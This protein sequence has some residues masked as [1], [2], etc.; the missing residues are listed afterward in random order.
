MDQLYLKHYLRTQINRFK[1]LI[2]QLV[3]HLWVGMKYLV[4]L[5]QLH[6]KCFNLKIKDDMNLNNKQLNSKFNYRM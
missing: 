1:R 2:Y 4:Q 6:S 3:D 5:C